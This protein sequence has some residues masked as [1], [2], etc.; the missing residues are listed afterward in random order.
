MSGVK[1]INIKDVK[2]E[3]REKEPPRTSWVLVSEK[4]M[5][6]KNISMGVNE[7]CAGAL[8][9]RHNHTEEEVMFFISG[10]GKF[11]TDD[12]EIHLEP[13]VCLYAP[14]GVSHEIINTGD[15]V[16]RFVW[17]F[18]PQTASHRKA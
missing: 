15:E 9:K 13:G 2:G 17:A 7:S 8:V 5:G 1:A 10:H 14:P 6:S 18:S 12:Q 11:V 3:R 16:L 4:T